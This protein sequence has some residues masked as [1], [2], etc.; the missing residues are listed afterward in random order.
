MKV[1]YFA[2]GIGPTV[3]PE[4]VR[5]VVRRGRFEL[6]RQNVRASRTGSSAAR[7]IAVEKTPVSARA[8][9]NI[10]ATSA[11]AGF[12]SDFP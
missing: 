3:N 7:L 10:D 5:M 2:V 4:L 6:F 12:R 1:G 8:W 11:E 9:A